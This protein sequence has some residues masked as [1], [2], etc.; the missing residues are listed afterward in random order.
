MRIYIVV[1]SSEGYLGKLR[2]DRAG[3]SSTA[4]VFERNFRLVL[5]SMVVGTAI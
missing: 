4:V 1:S 5:C 3:A 2:T